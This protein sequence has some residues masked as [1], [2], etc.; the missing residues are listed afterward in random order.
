MSASDITAKLTDQDRPVFT[1]G[2]AAEMVEVSVHTLRMYG[3]YPI[4]LEH[5]EGKTTDG[6]W[7]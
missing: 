6:F 2:V 3:R 7:V 5:W 1:I 4:S